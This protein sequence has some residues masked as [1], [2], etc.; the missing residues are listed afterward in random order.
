LG[1]Q[2]STT[3]ATWDRVTIWSCHFAAMYFHGTIDT[4]LAGGAGHLALG[5]GYGL[6]APR[7]NVALERAVSRTAQR[8]VGRT[9]PAGN[10]RVVQTRLSV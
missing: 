3:V 2:I 4:C 6:F 9:D 5:A 10:Y 8:Y 7:D 1:I